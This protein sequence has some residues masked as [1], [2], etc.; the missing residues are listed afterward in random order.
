MTEQECLF[1][2]DKNDM[3]CEQ[4]KYTPLSFLCCACETAVPLK[5]SIEYHMK[6]IFNMTIDGTK[7][8]KTRSILFNIV[9]YGMNTTIYINHKKI[10]NMDFMLEADEMTSSLFTKDLV[11]SYDILGNTRISK[12]IDVNNINSK[13]KAQFEHCV[14]V[15]CFVKS[16][17]SENIFQTYINKFI[18][19]RMTCIEWMDTT[20]HARRNLKMVLYISMQMLELDSIYKIKEAIIAKN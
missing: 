9:K 6:I 19:Q 16:Q 2:F 13:I 18:K 12:I 4:G 7:N 8:E 5:D 15:I 20:E 3:L 1:L 17:V 11:G 10:Y 14:R